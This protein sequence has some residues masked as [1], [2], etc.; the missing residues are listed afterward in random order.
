MNDTTTTRNKEAMRD[1]IADWMPNGRFD[2]IRSIIAPECVTRRAG[3]ANLYGARNDAIPEKGNFLEWLEAGWKPLSEAL[4]EQHV[5]VHEVIGEG[6]AVWAHY[7][8]TVLH[9]GQFVGVPAT[10]RTVEW[11]EVAIA[12]FGPDGKIVDLWFMCEELKL[13]LQLGFTLKQ[14]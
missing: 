12:H 4:G 14:G 3:F 10:G 9:R 7:H 5:A 13:A 11:D 1:L 2:K 8:M 6:N